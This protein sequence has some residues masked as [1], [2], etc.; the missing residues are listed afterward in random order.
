MMVFIISLQ[1]VFFLLSGCLTFIYFF[2]NKLLN[3]TSKISE[4]MFKLKFL[5]HDTSSFMISYKAKVVGGVFALLQ[6]ELFRSLVHHDNKL[7]KSCSAF[8]P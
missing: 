6:L 7:T 1:I 4:E 3:Q 2:I 8:I 5:R